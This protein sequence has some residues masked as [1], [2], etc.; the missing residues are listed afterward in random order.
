MTQLPQPADGLHPVK[1]GVGEGGQA[2]DAAPFGQRIAARAGEL[3]IG[4]RLIG[5]FGER[6]ERGGAESEFA[7]AP[8]DDEPLDP[9]A[10]A[11]RLDQE[12]QP[13]AVCVSS[14]RGFGNEGGPE[15]L[16]GIATSARGSSG[17]GSGI[18]DSIHSLITKEMEQ[19]AREYSW[20]GEDSR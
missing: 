19:I 11:D 20:R 13:V 7:A 15:R 16:V 8:A 9:V 5:R 14:S 4:E 18:D 1:G 12:V 3:A 17:F 10:G 2:L 6:D